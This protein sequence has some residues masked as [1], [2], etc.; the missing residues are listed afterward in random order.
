M[1]QKSL[2]TLAAG[3][4]AVD[5]SFPNLNGSLVSNKDLKGK[6]VLVDVWATWCAPCRAQLPHLQKLEEEL[7]DKNIAFVSMATDNE[8]DREKW[9]AMIAEKQMGGIQLFTSGP[10]NIFSQYYKINTI[11]RFLVFDQQG[12]IVSA[13]APRPSEPALKDI[14]LKTLNGK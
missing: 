4:K 12:R 2:A 13:D 11:P 7:K 1:Y 6:V 5:F 14:L 10:G 3:E 8:S 9:K